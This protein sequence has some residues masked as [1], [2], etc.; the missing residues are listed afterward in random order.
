MI[1]KRAARLKR[2]RIPERTLLL[3]GLVGGWP[4]GL[5]AQSIVR[6]KT[7]KASFQRQFWTSVVLNAALLFWLAA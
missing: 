5:L 1:D 3:L 2:R 7:V 4:G 6:H